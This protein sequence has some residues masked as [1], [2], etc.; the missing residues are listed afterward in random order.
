MEVVGP[1][2]FRRQE[3]SGVEHG[4]AGEVLGQ[5]LALLQKAADF[6]VGHV[7]GGKNVAGQIDHV[8]DD[9]LAHILLLQRGGQMIGS[10]DAISFR[11]QL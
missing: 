7:T 5:G 8:A 4:G 6:Q 1:M 9:Q 10:H 2:T 11:S 3:P